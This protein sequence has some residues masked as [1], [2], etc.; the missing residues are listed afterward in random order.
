MLLPQL[1]ELRFEDVGYAYVFYDNV[2]FVVIFR[3]VCCVVVAACVDYYAVY[4]AEF[5]KLP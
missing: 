1:L 5:P 3:G 4:H 2:I